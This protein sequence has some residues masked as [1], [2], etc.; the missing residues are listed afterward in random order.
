M[1]FMSRLRSLPFAKLAPPVGQKKVFVGYATVFG[2]RVM[3]GFQSLP[4]GQHAPQYGKI[5]NRLQLRESRKL[6]KWS[7]LSQVTKSFMS[8]F[9]LA[10]SLGLV[11][12]SRKFVR[13][14]LWKM[15]FVA[16]KVAAVAGDTR[17]ALGIFWLASKI[18]EVSKSSNSGEIHVMTIANFHV[19][20]IEMITTPKILHQ[21]Q[22]LLAVAVITRCSFYPC[23]SDFPE[24]YLTL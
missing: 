21:V 19:L 6:E 13:A 7:W 12:I 10:L 2:N 11:F 23:T 17:R 22:K 5:N 1:S 16:R 20:F 8:G 4:C 24:K 3:C 9:Y 14:G 18:D 15:R